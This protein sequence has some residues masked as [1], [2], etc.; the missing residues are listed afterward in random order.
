MVGCLCLS[1]ASACPSTAT[2]TNFCALAP[3]ANSA[4][5]R[6]KRVRRYARKA[7][8]TVILVGSTGCGKTTQIPQYVQ[9]AGW[10]EG[11]RVC[12][13]SQLRLL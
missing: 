11:G 3:P 8:T 4:T 2:A 6:L 10:G 12:V 1:S 13:V 5:G 9:E 7:F